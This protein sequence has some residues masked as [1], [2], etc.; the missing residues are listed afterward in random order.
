MQEYGHRLKKEVNAHLEKQVAELNVEIQEY[1]ACIE[2]RQQVL[3]GSFDL[4]SVPS[5]LI[6]NS[7]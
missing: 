3:V 2:S 5:V 1:S 6:S 4:E 7:T